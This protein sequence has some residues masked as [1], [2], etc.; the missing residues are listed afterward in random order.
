MLAFEDATVYT[1]LSY[2]KR[3]TQTPEAVL[4]PFLGALADGLVNDTNEVIFANTSGLYMNTDTPRMSLLQHEGEWRNG[5]NA[6]LAKK[7]ASK[8]KTGK[9]DLNP[10]AFTHASWDETITKNWNVFSKYFQRLK[11]AYAGDA[12]FREI[13]DTDIHAMNREPTKDNVNFL[14]EEFAVTGLWMQKK[15]KNPDMFIAYPGQIMPSMLLAMRM[16]F[17]G[18]RDIGKL[19]W[20]NTST[21][22]SPSAH[23]YELR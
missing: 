2:A 3:R 19:N 5:M 13:V 23:T 11:H 18:R 9:F 7:F 8:T 16:L 4:A 22:S 15:R 12:A 20:I 10:S 14:L 6:L 1:P 21:I 17:N